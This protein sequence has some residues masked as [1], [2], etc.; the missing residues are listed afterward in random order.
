M[1]PLDPKALAKLEAKRELRSHHF[2][3]GLETRDER[4]LNMESTAQ[5]SY[6]PPPVVLDK[7]AQLKQFQQM[8]SAL[9]KTNFVIGSREDH[10][11]MET[12]TVSMSAYKA[13]T[14][15]DYDRVAKKKS[16]FQKAHFVLGFE[17]PEVLK[18]RQSSLFHDTFK[19]FDK[20]QFFCSFW[21]I[22]TPQLC[23]PR[24]LRWQK[25]PRPTS[26][27]ITLVLAVMEA[28]TGALQLLGEHL[29]DMFEMAKL[30]PVSR[31]IKIPKSLLFPNSSS[32]LIHPKL[33]RHSELKPRKTDQLK[34]QSK[35]Q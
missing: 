21:F 15:E 33:S 2:S 1:A 24:V 11:A 14:K 13:P 5:A 27:P 28:D 22:K 10:S 9:R 19:P 23:T 31:S 3:F 12:A 16:N 18:A 8:K 4:K 32:L 7:A 35:V 34:A 6:H 29:N 26:G 20:G 25:R 30:S 17:D